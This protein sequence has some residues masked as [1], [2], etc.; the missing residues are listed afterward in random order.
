MRA[1]EPVDPFE[2]LRLAFPAEERARPAAGRDLGELLLGLR[3]AGSPE[4]PD[5]TDLRNGSETT[6]F[7]DR[8]SSARKRV[9]DLALDDLGRVVEE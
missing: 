5:L 1:V 2:D 9:A 4:G 7:L 8:G 3:K 6:L